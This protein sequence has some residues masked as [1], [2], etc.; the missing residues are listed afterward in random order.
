MLTAL[1]GLSSLTYIDFSSQ[2]LYGTLPNDVVF[3][4]LKYLNLRHNALQV[5]LH[6]SCPVRLH[7]S[8]CLCSSHALAVY[9]SLL[10]LV[11]YSPCKC[12]SH[13][14]CEVLLHGECSYLLSFLLHCF[15]RSI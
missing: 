5:H 10:Q 14:P 15:G 3:P 11:C 8:A 12:H 7:M 1:S 9:P 13:S 4:K 2:N 6:H